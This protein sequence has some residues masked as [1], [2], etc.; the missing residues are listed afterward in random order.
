MHNCVVSGNRVVADSPIAN[1]A[2]AGG[3]GSSGQLDIEDSVI[4]NNTVEYTGSLDF[5][6]QSGLAGGLS[7]TRRTPSRIRRRSSA[8]RGSPAITYAR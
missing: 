1:S 2:S 7:S 5:D 4:S 6:D 3:I 8:T